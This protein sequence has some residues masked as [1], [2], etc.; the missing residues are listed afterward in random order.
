MLEIHEAAV[1]DPEALRRLRSGLREID[2]QIA[3]DDFGTGQS[4]L[5]ELA[6]VPPDYVKFD[7]AFVRDLHLAPSRRRD[8]LLSLV[9]M[10][11][12]SGIVP[13]AEGVETEEEKQ[14]CG[15]VGFD[16]AQGYR[17]GLPTPLDLLSALD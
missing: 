7:M 15:E 2:I 8:T 1:T 3:F 16:L 4:R 9:Q 14:A 13:I 10:T 11:R 12:E 6:E 17:L 5:L